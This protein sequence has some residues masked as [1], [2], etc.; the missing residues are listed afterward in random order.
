V[1]DADKSTTNTLT[2]HLSSAIVNLSPPPIDENPSFEEVNSNTVACSDSA[3]LLPLTFDLLK[4]LNIHSDYCHR[5]H[6]TRLT[7]IL[8]TW[9]TVTN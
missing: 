2:T 6:E 1:E 8:E 4:Q 7:T 5:T 3:A 9:I